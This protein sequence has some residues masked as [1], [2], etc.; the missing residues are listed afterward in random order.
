[1]IRIRLCLAASLCLSPL[2][3]LAPATARADAMKP[4]AGASASVTHDVSTGG[5]GS[6]QAST[7]SGPTATASYEWADKVV[8]QSRYNDHGYLVGGSL[9]GSADAQGT[10]SELLRVKS[11]GGMGNPGSI[12]GSASAGILVSTAGWKEDAVL[13]TPPA[14]GALPDTIRLNFTMGFTADEEPNYY[15]ESHYAGMQLTANDKTIDIKKATR[16]EYFGVPG[17]PGYKASDF[18]SLTDRQSVLVDNRYVNLKVGTFHIDLP[19]NAS[20]VSD[21]FSLSLKAT[22]N[23]YAESNSGA[24]SALLGT[25]SLDSVTLPDGTLLADK[26]YGVAF[27]SGMTG[28]TSQVSPQPVP[29]PASVAMWAV[30]AAAGIGLV[31]RRAGGDAMREG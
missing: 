24:S 27:A 25:L 22:T 18:D 20:G 30:V 31:R 2:I 9:S 28:L 12:Y 13:L 6:P 11:L 17:T 26:G 5:Y 21:P 29:E 10:S 14:A 1:M 23:L 8:T 19:V 7:S 4:W 15:Y 16:Q 3:G